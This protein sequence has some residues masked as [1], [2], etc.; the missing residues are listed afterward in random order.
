MMDYQVDMKNNA[1]NK[2]ERKIQLRLNPDN[3]IRRECEQGKDYADAIR[4]ENFLFLFFS[5]SKK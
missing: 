2:Y 4:D 5:Q 1:W 3:C